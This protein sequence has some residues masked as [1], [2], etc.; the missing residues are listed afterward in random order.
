MD[1]RDRIVQVTSD[2]IVERGIHG[3]PISLIAREADVA[4]GTLYIYFKTKQDLVHAVYEKLL[5]DITKALLAKYLP[6]GSVKERFFA[7]HLALFEYLLDNPRHAKLL[8]YF[9][10]T[11]YI[12]VSVREKI[13]DELLRVQIDIL[14]EGRD[15][16][17]LKNEHPFP[18][19]SLWFVY[20]SLLFLVNKE[21]IRNRA[22]IKP[23]VKQRILQM[24]W[25]GIQTSDTGELCEKMDNID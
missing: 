22:A 6:S 12:E 13:S 20:G 16:G 21:Q 3:V 17:L 24:W 14:T 2:C 10:T 25:D 9:S 5:S 15:K 23:E 4:V 8:L 19:V 11:P 1:K 7:Y 18:Y